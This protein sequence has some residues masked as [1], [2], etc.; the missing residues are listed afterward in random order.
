MNI[1]FFI[2]RLIDF[3]EYVQVSQL[4]LLGEIDPLLADVV[5][6]D[7]SESDSG[8]QYYG[9]NQSEYDSPSLA[10]GGSTGHRPLKA[11]FEIPIRGLKFD[12]IHF[13]SLFQ[14]VSALHGN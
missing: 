5:D 6:L 13:Q 8:S 12:L 4:F 7:R 10:Y 11:L 14:Y 9:C 3:Q 2:S 1:I